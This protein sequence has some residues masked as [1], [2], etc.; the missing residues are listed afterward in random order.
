MSSLSHPIDVYSDWID[1][2]EELN[3]GSK[4]EQENKNNINSIYYFIKG[5]KSNLFHNDI[6]CF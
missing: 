4:C 3:P 6:F 2:C 5:K 1:A